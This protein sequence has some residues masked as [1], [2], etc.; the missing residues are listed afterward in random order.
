MT[1]TQTLQI[2]ERY[3]QYEDLRA[4][5]FSEKRWQQEG[6][7]STKWE[8]VNFL[9]LMLR[10]L[11]QNGIGYPKVLLLKKKEI[12]RGTFRLEPVEERDGPSVP[13]TANSGDVCR[14][15]K[16]QR[17]FV[18]PNGNGTLC[19]TCLGGRRKVESK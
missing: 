5:A 6:R 14:D 13:R 7:P 3:L 16:G 1:L 19:M 15:C 8:M 18:L 12:Q 4:M 17:F 2:Q 11:K 10:E 9:E